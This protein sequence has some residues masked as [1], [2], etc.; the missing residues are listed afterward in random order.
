MIGS[1][2]EA[3]SP[4]YLLGVGVT[5]KYTGTWNTATKKARE[6]FIAAM[7]PK[8]TENRINAPHL[9]M[10]WFLEF[11]SP[12]SVSWEYLDEGK[13]EMKS[14]LDTLE[15][16]STDTR[17][18]R[19]VVYNSQFCLSRQRKSSYILYKINLLNTDTQLMRTLCM[20]CG[21]SVEPVELPS[22]FTSCLLIAYPGAWSLSHS[23]VV[24]LPKRE[25]ACILL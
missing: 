7:A 17:L 6:K 5:N 2:E 3:A 4:T 24:E 21:S 14:V 18:I 22:C 25:S 23:P 15:T 16:R 12:E 11:T 1:K 19:I 10:W 13:R 20:S 8:R 9:S